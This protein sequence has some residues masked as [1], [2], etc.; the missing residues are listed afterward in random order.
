MNQAILGTAVLLAVSAAQGQK[1]RGAP[2]FEAERNVARACAIDRIVQRELKANDLLPAHPCSDEVF[3]RRLYLDVLGTLPEPGEVI[4]FLEDNGRKKRAALIDLVLEREEFANYW[5]MK[6]CDLLRVKAEF[7]INLWP[8]AVQAYYRWIHDA[9]RENRSY[10]WFARELL[11]AS[12]SNFRVPQVNFYRAVQGREPSALARVAA[13]TFMGVRVENWPQNQR[14]GLEACFSRIAFKGTAE[15]KEEIIYLDPE[16]AEAFETILPDATKVTIGPDEDPRHVFADWLIDR[17]NPWFTRNIVNRVW[18]WLLGRGLIHEPDDLRPDNPPVCPDLLDH[19]QDELVDADYDLK[20]ILRLILNSRTYQR[21]SIPRSA[22]AESERFF[23]HY[24]VRRLDGE[25]LLDALCSVFGAEQG[26]SSTIPEPFTHIPEHHRAVELADGSITSPF[27]EMFGR[28]AR[29]TG[30][31]SERDNEPSD[32]QRL[33]LLNSSQVRNMIRRSGRL[34][35]WAAASAREPHRGIDALYLT[36][37]S[38]YPTEEEIGIA[39]EYARSSGLP[40]GEI[41]ADL[42]WALI[43]TKEFLYRH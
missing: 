27:L 38:R 40:R 8:N 31:E 4:A 7:P 15:W 34:W 13:L 21:S 14:A 20:H 11:T 16:G 10:D 32:A 5:T 30:L 24:A 23:G 18:S 39:E 36:V 29:D 26:Y 3:I 25:V 41:A 12:G 19:L 2:P 42:A 1:G 17:K 28:P 37:L 9:V 22:E 35:T 33:Y 43:N 6:W